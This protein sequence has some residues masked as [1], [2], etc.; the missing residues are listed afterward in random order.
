MWVFWCA[1]ALRL[2]AEDR[3]R[4]LFSPQLASAG[5]EAQ[6]D[7]KSRELSDSKKY[8]ASRVRVFI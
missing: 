6:M 8:N 5:I 3:F 4:D 1:T 7:K 2:E